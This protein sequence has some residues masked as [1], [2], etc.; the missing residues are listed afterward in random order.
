MQRSE[1]QHYLNELLQV[2]RI[3][4]YCPNGLQVEGRQT[5][6]KIVTG[7]TRVG[8]QC[9]TGATLWLAEARTVIE[10]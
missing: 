7:V 6:R 5:I 8:E 10:R 4:D 2:D 9:A 1:L 3:R